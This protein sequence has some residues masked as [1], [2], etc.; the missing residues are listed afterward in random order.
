MTAGA[1]YILL[2][3]DMVNTN[4][5]K[6]RKSAYNNAHLAGVRKASWNQW[7]FIVNEF[8]LTETIPNAILILST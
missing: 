2:A 1:R 5:S 4:F 8:Y 3:N 6:G 7:T